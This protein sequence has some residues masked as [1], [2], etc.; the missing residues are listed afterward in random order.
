MTRRLTI[1]TQNGDVSGL[2]DTSTDPS[3]L[4]VVAHGAGAGME[5]PFLQALAENLVSRGAATLRYQF[6]YME[7]KKNRVDSPAVAAAVVRAAVERAQ[8]LMP[9]VP[10]L[11]GGKSFGG[12]MTSH[13]Q[14]NAALPGVYGLAFLGFPLHAPGKPSVDRAAHLA[15]VAV[16]MLFLQGTRDEFARLDL[17]QQVVQELGPRATLVLTADGDHSF[18]VRKRSGSTSGQAFQSLCDSLVTW[19]TS[20]PHPSR[21]P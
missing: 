3:F 10:L 5:H 4:Y 16:P 14:A 20:L 2:F 11:A 19:A 6:P 1:D 15:Q 8:Q 12:R 21:I 13:A 9:N 17:V 18:A 7:A